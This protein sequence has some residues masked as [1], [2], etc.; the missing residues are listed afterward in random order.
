MS[1]SDFGSK[2][3]TKNAKISILEFRNFNFVSKTVFFHDVVVFRSKPL[4][5]KKT[6]NSGPNLRLTCY[7]NNDSILG[8][9]SF[10]TATIVDIPNLVNSKLTTLKTD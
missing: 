9:L 6:Q 2:L 8:E 1:E 3:A 4:C 10:L 5:F 7:P